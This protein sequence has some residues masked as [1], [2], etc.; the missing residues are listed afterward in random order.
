[1]RT[2]KA[3]AIIRFFLLYLH[4]RFFSK[5]TFICNL[6]L[7]LAAVMHYFKHYINEAAFPQPLNFFKGTVVIL[8]EF[9]WILNFIFTILVAVYLLMKKK[10]GVPKWLILFNACMLLFAI[11]YFFIDKS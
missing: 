10:T 4:M 1:M 5:I 8:A 7:L 6:C 2:A 11:Y 3:A 9:G